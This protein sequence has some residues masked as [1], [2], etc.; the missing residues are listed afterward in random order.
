MLGDILKQSKYNYTAIF[1][2]S[3]NIMNGSV[4]QV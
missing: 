4:I 1:V 2:G 3:N